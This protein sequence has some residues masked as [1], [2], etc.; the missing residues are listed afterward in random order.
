V[1]KNDNVAALVIG[2]DD[3]GAWNQLKEQTNGRVRAMGRQ[4]DLDLFHCAADIYLDSFSIG[5]LTASLE[6]GL[7]G[8]PI[9]NIYNNVPR[10]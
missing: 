10:P 9:I 3:D 4:E 5:S 8:L 7:K 1:Q 6:A 2:P